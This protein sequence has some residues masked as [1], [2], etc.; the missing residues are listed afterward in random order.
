MEDKMLLII[1]SLLILLIAIILIAFSYNSFIQLKNNINK[2]W[3]NI[4]VS[5]KQRSDELPNLIATVKGY[6]GHER[7]TLE[8][9]TNERTKVISESSL[10]KKAAADTNVSGAIKTIFAVAEN[11][12]NLKADENF[13]KLQKRIT[14]IENM[15]ADRR[16]FFNDCINIYN[17]KVH[18]FPSLLV[19]KL[20]KL[21]DEEY[22]KVAE[23]DKHLVKV[24]Y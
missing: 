16:E 12:P 23:E 18:S 17:T 15:L 11:Y 1:I 7:G 22:F 20:M 9:L 10:S 6:M 24:S 4:D 3:A 13:L 14:E 19:A 2:S 8:V 21:K 5:L